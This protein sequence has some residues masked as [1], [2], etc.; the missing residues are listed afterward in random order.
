[1]ILSCS[2]AVL[3]TASLLDEL[4][5]TSLNAEATALLLLD[6]GVPVVARLQYSWRFSFKPKT[7]INPIFGNAR[8]HGGRW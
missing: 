6:L 4:A 2:S 5:A 3:V 8:S 7:K 1:M